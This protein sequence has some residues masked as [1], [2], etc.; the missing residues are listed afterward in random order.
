MFRSLAFD[1]CLIGSTKVKSS[2]SRCADS[3]SIR[4]VGW[5]T[6]PAHRTKLGCGEVRQRRRQGIWKASNHQAGL[7]K[8]D[9]SLYI[10]RSQMMLQQ[11]S[12]YH[13]VNKSLY[14]K[15]FSVPVRAQ[16]QDYT[17]YIP[18]LISLMAVWA[19]TETL[20]IPL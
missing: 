6:E 16:Q 18:P 10:K 3:A 20:K 1:T 15:I 11:Q 13:L 7:T 8:P 5:C 17:G 9:N 4:G 2:C 14:V 19:V 12:I